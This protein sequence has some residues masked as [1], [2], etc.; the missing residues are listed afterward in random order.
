[1]ALSTFEIAPVPLLSASWELELREVAL[2]SILKIPEFA[3][4][5]VNYK[6][7]AVILHF[8]ATY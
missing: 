8:K 1:M 2:N 6:E 7:T 3:G 5:G 4:N